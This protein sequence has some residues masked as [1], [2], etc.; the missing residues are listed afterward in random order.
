MSLFSMGWKCNLVFYKWCAT[1]M[2]SGL[3][4]LPDV[5]EQEV[6][7]E[8]LAT[9]Q[10]FN[11]LHLVVQ[12]V[13]GWNVPCDVGLG[14][15]AS[16]LAIQNQLGALSDVIGLRILWVARERRNHTLFEWDHVRLGD[17]VRVR[18]H[19]LVITLSK[20]RRTPTLLYNTIVWNRISRRNKCKDVPSSNGSRLVKWML[21]VLP[22]IGTMSPDIS[23]FSPFFSQLDWGWGVP[24]Y[25]QSR[26]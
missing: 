5:R 1:H 22:P 15:R 12:I 17:T 20:T 10:P 11:H 16:D 8:V 9:S 7:V 24:S 6:S 18:H 23:K 25:S 13:F 14:V 3:T 19:A 21:P 2:Y 26:T 4:N